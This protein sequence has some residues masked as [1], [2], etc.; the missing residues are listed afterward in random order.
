MQN[1]SIAAKRFPSR[2]R[3]F[4]MKR[5]AV[6]LLFLFA[7][8]LGPRTAEAAIAVVTSTPDLASIAKAVGG[9]RVRV[10]ALALSTQDPHWV[11]ARPHLALALAKAD[12]LL[13][14]GAD[15]E[16][17]WLPPLLTGSRNG[18]VQRG[19]RGYLDCSTLVALLEVPSGKVDRS[20]GDVHPQG[21]P[22]YTLD[23]RRVERVAVGIGKRL[24][25]LDPAGR[26]VYL[27][28]TRR[29]VDDLRAARSIWEG[30]LAKLKGRSVLAYHRS[31]SYLADWLGLVVVDHLEPRPGIPPNPR[32]IAHVIEVGKTQK[33]VG[34]L[35]ETWFPKNASGVV[36]DKLKK[37]LVVLSTLPDPAKGESYIARMN[38]IVQAL[39]RLETP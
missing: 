5:V 30:K 36:A 21:N 26:A 16:V 39:R 18:N 7:F 38:A 11:D 28:G 27:E 37:P 14:T 19:A 15:L 17:G 10:T 33:V 6:L 25:E 29:F 1:I 12:L 2:D 4:S 24:S 22:H 23:P 35:Q 34:V 3:R 9:D 8:V 32:H 31:L 20:Q 13:V